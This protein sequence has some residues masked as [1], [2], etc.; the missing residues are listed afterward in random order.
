MARR[1]RWRFNWSEESTK[2]NLVR[3]LAAVGALI[4]LRY[5]KEWAEFF[6]AAGMFIGALMGVLRS[7]Q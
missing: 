4:A 7:D 3:L 5:G 1:S 2:R 6:I